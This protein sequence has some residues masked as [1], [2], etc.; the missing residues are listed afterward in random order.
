MFA[1]LAPDQSCEIDFQSMFMKATDHFFSACLLIFYIIYDYFFNIAYLNLL[2]LLLKYFKGKQ[3]LFMTKTRV[4]L[5]KIVHECAIF[6][7]A[8]LTQ[9]KRIK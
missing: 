2:A 8:F 7:R 1:T 4:H 3:L 6:F 9:E 5:N